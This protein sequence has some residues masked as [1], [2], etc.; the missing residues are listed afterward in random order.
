MLG[1]EVFNDPSLIDE[2]SFDVKV[3]KETH[4]FH[5]MKQYYAAF[6]IERENQLA[7]E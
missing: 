5:Y 6:L 3:N 4:V 2:F 7:N 1:T